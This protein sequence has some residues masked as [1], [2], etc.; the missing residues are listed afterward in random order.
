MAP[1]RC[2]AR[3][4]TASAGSSTVS[5]RP[6]AT[7][8]RGA[9]PSGWPAVLANR[10]PVSWIVRVAGIAAARMQFKRLQTAIRMPIRP[11]SVDRS[12]CMRFATHKIS[13]NGRDVAVDMGGAV[14]PTVV[15][16]H[17]IPGWRG[18]WRPVAE[19]LATTCR[20][21]MPDLLGFGESADPSPG[22]FHATGQAKMVVGLI[23]ALALGPVH[24]VG[25]DFG[26]PIAVQTIRREPR[27]V[28]S[29]S[30]FSTAV[31]ADT[32]IPPLLQLAR[33][34]LIGELLFRFAFGRLGLRGL[35]R[36][37]VRDH[38]ALPRSAF[39]DDL[40]RFPRGLRWTQR[41]FLA[42]LRNL[43][44]LYRNIEDTLPTIRMPTLVGWGDRIPSSRWRS[45]SG[46]PA[47]SA[48]RA[49]PP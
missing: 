15:L 38:I 48:E 28:R 42:S 29:L 3:Y 34:P 49:S 18:S 37:A 4:T 44:R 30:L 35:W 5:G 14:G 19:R 7:G 10:A 39:L 9:S 22:D 2:D 21:V 47:V 43:P 17:G 31:F 12:R 41:I 46:P 45:G 6:S 20:V 13:V 32:P 26:G 23:D 1:D 33:I 27:L 40:T 36:A 8:Y 16:L 11:A 25:H 24:L